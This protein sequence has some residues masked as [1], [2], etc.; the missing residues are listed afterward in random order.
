MADTAKK[1]PTKEEVSQTFSLYS[2]IKIE[3]GS[4]LI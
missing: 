1:D 2:S 3:R 4:V